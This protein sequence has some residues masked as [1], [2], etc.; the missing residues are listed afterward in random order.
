VL[1]AAERVIARDGNGAS[2]EAIAFEAGVTKPVVYA[3]VGGRAALSNAL[4]ERLAMRLV[5]A[6]GAEMDSNGSLDRTTLAA[7]FRSSLEMIGAHSELFLYVTRGATEDAPERRL[8]LAGKSAGPLAVLLSQWR[9]RN[10]HD[11]AV[12]LPWAYAII[13]MLNLVSLWWIEEHD[14]P[15]DVLAD[16]LAELVWPGLDAGGGV[17]G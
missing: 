2:L 10:G 9:V 17:V 3:R 5:A 14:R 8:Y 15:A 13:G 4:A 11:G 16:Q 12:A 6:A 7:F 1:D